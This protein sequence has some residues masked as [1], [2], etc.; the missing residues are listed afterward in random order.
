[1]NAKRNPTRIIRIAKGFDQRDP[2]A[3]RSNFEIVFAVSGLVTAP[4]SRESIHAN[5][6]AVI[7]LIDASPFAGSMA[8]PVLWDAEV[9][10]AMTFV[11]E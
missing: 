3:N 6:A 4:S 11:A 2:M 1:M 9:L 5:R 8:F 10:P 7:S